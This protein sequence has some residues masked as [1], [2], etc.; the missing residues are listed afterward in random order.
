[1]DPAFWRTRWRENRIGFHQTEPTEL[2]VKS[3]ATVAPHPRS[4]V[5]VPL[6]GKSKDLVHLLE[7]GHEVVGVEL[8][9]DALI[10]LHD[11][12]ELT[13]TKRT[14]GAFTVFESGA[15]T[16]YAGDFFDLDPALTGLFDWAFDRAALVSWDV[17]EQ[18]RYVDHLLR[19]LRPSGR[20]FLI[21]VEYDPTEMHGPPCTAPEHQV[22]KLLSPHGTLEHLEERDALNERFR[23]RGCKRM[24]E[25]AWLFTKHA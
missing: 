11:E 9:E 14:E 4:R 23:A 8:V 6:C 1:M 3:I 16:T 22:R 12:N 17:D 24:S 21:S 2:L 13:Y 10:A 20:L 19:F 18:P 25:H 7:R 5:F 15:M